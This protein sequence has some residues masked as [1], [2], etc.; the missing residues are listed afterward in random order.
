MNH[1]VPILTKQ[2]YHKYTTNNIDIHL[3][4]YM[5]DFYHI[6]FFLEMTQGAS[7]TICFTK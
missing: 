4:S 6:H 3:Y 2:V 5:L 7:V 1:R